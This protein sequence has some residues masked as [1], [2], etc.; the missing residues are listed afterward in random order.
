MTNMKTKVVVIIIALALFLA[1]RRAEQRLADQA[2]FYV[3]TLAANAIISL[4]AALRFDRKG[5]HRRTAKE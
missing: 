5:R 2:D 3:T 4:T 1:R